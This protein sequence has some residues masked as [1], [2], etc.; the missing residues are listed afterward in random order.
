MTDSLFAI[1]HPDKSATVYYNE[2]YPR[3]TARAKRP[4]EKGEPITL[5][6]IY[7]VDHVALDEI[8]IS[9]DDGVC[10]LFSCGW[11]K[12]LFFDFGPLHA[13]GDRRE[14]TYDLGAVLADC[15]TRVM[16]QERFSIEDSVWTEMFRQ[17]WFP[18]AC[19][20]CDRI[21]HTIEFAREGLEIDAEL[22]SFRQHAINLVG[23]RLKEW[24]SELAFADH[25]ALFHRAYE[26]FV[27]GDDVSATA[28][29]FPRIEGIIRDHQNAVTPDAPLKQKQFV[30]TGS[31]I[32]NP[33]M[34]TTSTF[35]PERFRQYLDEVFFCSFDG[36]K[37]PSIASRHTIAHGV[38]PAELFDRKS[39]TIAFLILLQISTVIRMTAGKK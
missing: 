21:R 27:V 19:L 8:K 4:I 38:A 5:D 6:D 29:L 11:R 13:G 7:G 9:K 26:R 3:F 24:E 31:G 20:S 1:F 33:A 36:K 17:R 28:I 39:A 15:R 35:L 30:A 37:R 25:I 12:G 32:D 34:G 18:F 16:F 22:E 10:Y 23:Q 2:F 14:S